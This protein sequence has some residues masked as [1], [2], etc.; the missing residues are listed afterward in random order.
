MRKICQ[1]A[2][3]M[4]VILKICLQIKKCFIFWYVDLILGTLFFL[5]FVFCSK[6]PKYIVGSTLSSTYWKADS[7]RR[8]W[9]YIKSDSFFIFS[10][11]FTKMIDYME[12]WKPFHYIAITSHCKNKHVA[13][14]AQFF[15]V[16]RSLFKG[17]YNTEKAKFNKWNL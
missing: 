4:P 17:E 6:I 5:L 11:P 2:H 10:N 3:L 8:F 1:D 14:S 7:K 9:K 15:K 16:L 13:K 12:F